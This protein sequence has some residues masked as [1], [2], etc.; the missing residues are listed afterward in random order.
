M[1]ITTY[2]SGATLDTLRRLKQRRPAQE[3]CE[4]CAAPLE[5]Q[6]AHLLEPTERRI[7]CSCDP[8]A[9]LFQE[10][11]RR[12]RRIPRDTY[13]LADFV[14]EELQWEALSIPINL[15]F[16]FFSS[17]ANR[18]VAYYPSPAGAMESS[19][20]IQGWEQII[21]RH[22]R[23]R[24]MAIDVEALLVNRLATPHEYYIAPIDRCYELCGIVRRRWSGFTGGDEVWNEIG[25]F[26]SV[27][28]QQSVAL[29]SPRA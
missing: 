28:K 9:F 25:R 21:C 26:F 18:A 3:P 22:P 11:G 7:V 6:H 23:L 4:L 1:G 2:I 24:E 20:E 5:E 16:V 14:L 12:Y 29:E 15:V 27:L 13:L 10:P 17:V 19:L 8:C